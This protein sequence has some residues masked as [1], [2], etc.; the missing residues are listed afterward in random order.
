MLDG[1]FN[2]GLHFRVLWVAAVAHISA[3]IRRADKHAIHPFDIEDLRQIFQ[4]FAG[5]NLHEYAHGVIG[6]VD[7]IRDAIPA[8]GA[9]QRATD[10]A[11][12]GW[13]IAGG[14]DRQPRLF[15]ILHHRHQQ[16]LRADIQQL[17]DLHRI[18]PRRTHHRLAGVGRNGLQLGQHRWYIVGRVFAVDQQP[19]E[20]RAGQQ[21]G[22]VAAAQ[23]KPQ[24][25]LR[26]ARF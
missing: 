20:A 11:D 26:T 2:G 13:R 16:G 21:F 19:V 15:G 9:G 14:S 24:A 10:A 25:D 7:I 3:E 12:A 23:P 4:R 8:R 1:I 22:A 18:V 17:F 6:P 5:L